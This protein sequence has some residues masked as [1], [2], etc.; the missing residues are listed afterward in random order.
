MSRDFHYFNQRYFQGKYCE[1]LMQVM[2]PQ[3]LKRELLA[4]LY[5]GGKRE[6]SGSG[7]YL[8]QRNQLE[9]S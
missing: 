2:H 6:L 3:H 9:K 4:I 5:Q 1:Y 8:H 7:S